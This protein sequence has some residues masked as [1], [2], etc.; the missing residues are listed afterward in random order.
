MQFCTHDNLQNCSLQTTK[1]EEANEAQ[2]N[3]VDMS[4]VRDLIQQLVD[5]VGKVKSAI[6]SSNG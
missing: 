6:Q 1:D 2:H 5:V 3:D 4:K